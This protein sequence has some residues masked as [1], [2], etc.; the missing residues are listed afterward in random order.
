MAIGLPGWFAFVIFNIIQIIGG[1]TL[2][3]QNLKQRCHQ[4]VSRRIS[5]PDIVTY[6]VCCVGSL[7]FRISRLAA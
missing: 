6:C 7:I 3:V 1:L 2:S 4:A 5:R